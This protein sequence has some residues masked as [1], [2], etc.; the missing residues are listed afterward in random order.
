MK[1]LAPTHKVIPLEG[2]FRL[3]FGDVATDGIFSGPKSLLRL[4]PA[5]IHPSASLYIPHPFLKA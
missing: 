2:V 1:I 4:L 3:V 5:L